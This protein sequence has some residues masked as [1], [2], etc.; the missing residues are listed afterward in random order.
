[1]RWTK[2]S[3]NSQLYTKHQTIYTLCIKRS[4]MSKVYNHKDKQHVVDKLHAAKTCFSPIEAHKQI[5]TANCNEVKSPLSPMPWRKAE[6]TFQKGFHVLDENEIK[7]FVLCW[8]FLT[9]IQKSP[10]MTEFLHCVLTLYHETHDP[11]IR[12]KVSHLCLVYRH[13]LAN[14]FPWIISY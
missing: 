8:S 2:V 9:Y 6:S 13:M 7:R 1:M 3:Y 11:V 4:H 12:T 10:H 5:A 14:W